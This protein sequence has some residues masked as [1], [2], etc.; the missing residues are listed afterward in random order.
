MSEFAQL[1]AA[2]AAKG[3]AVFPLR[4]GTKEP[5]TKNGMLA[6]TTEAE[7]VAAWWQQSPEAN[8]GVAL[9]PSGLVVLDVDVDDDKPGAASLAALIDQYGELPDTLTARTGGG[10]YHFVFAKGEAEVAHRIGFRPGIDL[11]SNGYIVVEPSVNARK[12]TETTGLYAWDDAD[13]LVDDLTAHLAPVPEWMITQERAAAAGEGKFADF[14]YDGVKAPVDNLID[15]QA[16]PGER[17]V[18]LTRLVGR[19]I[20]EAD[21][22]LDVTTRALGWN[23]NQNSPLPVHEVHTILRS[24]SAKHYENTGQRLPLDAPIKVRIADDVAPPPVEHAEWR[25]PIPG[26][27]GRF[28]DYFHGLAPGE[29]PELAT[30]T[31]LAF[32]SLVCGRRYRETEGNNFTHLYCLAIGES[33]TGKETAYKSIHK[34]LAACNLEHLLTTGYTSRAAVF[35]ALRQAPRHIAVIDEMGR[36]LAAA[37][38]SANGHQEQANTV[39]MEAFNRDCIKPQE[40][41]VAGDERSGEAINEPA[42]TMLGLTTPE[43]VLTTLSPAHI[44]DGFLPRWIVAQSFRQPPEQRPTFGDGPPPVELTSWACQAAFFPTR[45]AALPEID[46]TEPNVTPVG[47]TPEGKAVIDAVY[48]EEREARQAAK[49]AMAALPNRWTQKTM[50]VATILAVSKRIERPVIDEE[51][52]QWAAD[53]IRHAEA[54]AVRLYGEDGSQLAVDDFTRLSIEME[55]AIFDQGAEGMTLTEVGRKFRGMYA[56]TVRDRLIESEIVMR[57]DRGKQGNGPKTMALVHGHFVQTE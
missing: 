19:W 45:G 30:L 56:K 41:A 20:T 11:L 35:R 27:L 48:Q 49:G 22:W 12:L 47:Y 10:G 52:A 36:Y 9:K 5:A 51:C 50:R 28:V 6:A 31:A 3:W 38:S 4:P 37:S 55:R 18:T 34:A 24:I 1:A 23:S 57:I 43:K 14:D 13:P 21:C 46:T 39:L 25:R 26:T 16:R 44:A 2:Y 29:N 33:G 7:Q 15:M 32:G 42:I 17:N 53:Y 54:A 8:I 40:Y